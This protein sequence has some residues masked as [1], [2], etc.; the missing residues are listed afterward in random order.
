MALAHRV[1][2]SGTTRERGESKAKQAKQSKAS[3]QCGRT[4]KK[5]KNIMELRYLEVLV[6]NEG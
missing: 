5:Q 6:G 3:E 4:R 1:S 2:L